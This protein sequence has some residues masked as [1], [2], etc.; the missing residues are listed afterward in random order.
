MRI[1]LFYE[2]FESD[3]NAPTSHVLR[4]I[5]TEL[6]ARGHD[7]EVYEPATGAR[8]VAPWHELAVDEAGAFFDAYPML[9]S[10]KYDVRTLEVA[11]VLAD[12]DLVIVHE[13]NDAR[14]TCRIA[15]H[16]AS[17]GH[18]TLL[19]HDTHHRSITDPA[20][21]AE[22]DLRPFDGVLTSGDAVA[23]LYVERGWARRAWTWPS[24]ADVRVF[25]PRRQPTVFPL[26]AAAAAAGDRVTV[27][28]IPD[29]DV[30]W[31]GN[32]ADNERG[33]AL[34]EFLATPVS[35]LGA[36]A[37][38]YGVGYPDAVIAQLAAAGVEYRGWVGNYEV[39]DVFAQFKVTIHLPRAPYLASLPGIVP[40]RL[41]EAM[42]CGIPLVSAGWRDGGGLVT[43]G[44]HFLVADDAD[45]MTAH[46][47]AL[48]HRPD[49]RGR[50]AVS[51]L[52]AIHDAHTCAHRVDQL[53]ALV[54]DIAEESP[55]MWDR[56]RVVTSCWQ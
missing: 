53:L 55:A 4:G 11:R 27:D 14:L 13:A 10:R 42:A 16:R 35:R 5:A 25:Y 34:G 48:L 12:A 26:E 54:L 36:R 43:P 17:G 24:A 6:L 30:V 22:L 52:R 37:A 38:V 56:P 19:F 41:F 21:L 40:G 51:G 46:L 8:H 44:E 15:R 32:Y 33:D 28:D 23:R 3:W 29:G 2:S 49:T 1:L 18:Y 39:P 20:R 7:V 45:E 50:F 47:A 31:V 9:S